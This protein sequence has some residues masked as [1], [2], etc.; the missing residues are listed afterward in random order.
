NAGVSVVKEIEKIIGDYRDKRICVFAGKGN[1]GGDGFVVARHAVNRGAKVKVFLVG[2]KSAVTGDAQVNLLTLERMDIEVVELRR[3]RDWDKARIAAQFADCLVDALLGTGIYGE[4]SAEFAQAVDLIDEAAKPVI[5]IDIPSGIHS[6]TGQVCGKAVTAVCTVTFGLPKL[7]LL[8]YPGV[9][10]TGRVVVADIGIPHQLL[11]DPQ[12]RQNQI[13][14]EHIRTILPKRHSAA[15]KGSCG[16]V[17]VVAGSQGLTGAAFLSSSAALRAGAGLVTLGIAAGLHDIME[18]KLTEVMTHPLPEVAKGV[19]GSSSLEDIFLLASDNNALA[20]GP[21]LGRAQ[22]TLT[23]VRDVVQLAERPLVIDADALFALVGHTEILSG[24]SVLPVV[25]PHPGEMARLMGRSIGEIN[26]NR[27]ATARQAAE[28]WGSIVVLKGA[29][30][31]IAFPD[32]EIYINLTGNPGMA[33]GGTGDVL[34]GII[35]GLIAQGLSSHDAAVA[36]VYLHGLAGDMAAG[37]Y[38]SGLIAGDLLPMIP[39]AVQK[40]IG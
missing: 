13:T 32:G 39:A 23:M 10:Y 6:D 2:Q 5:S 3:E 22:D 31:V 35:A 37:D 4:I 25:T 24:A 17:L 11:M 18:I 1:N 34:T 29:H 38:N 15:H 14:M 40:I 19:L 27:I 28:Q 8:L 36:G 16:K 9:D 30:T 20:I 33:T 12:I 21:G 7:G 26:G